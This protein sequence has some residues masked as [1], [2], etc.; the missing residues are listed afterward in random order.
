MYVLITVHDKLCV[1]YNIGRQRGRGRESDRES[2]GRGWPTGE[3]LM[4]FS[5][6]ICLLSHHIFTVVP[7]I[8]VGGVNS[9]MTR[10][11]MPV[12]QKCENIITK[13]VPLFNTANS[14]MILRD[15]AVSIIANWGTFVKNDT[16]QS[17]L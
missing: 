10:H 8:Q 3:S 15:L 16:S 13:R 12:K 9:H 5:Q 14:H 2:E 4:E 7:R 17:L 1:R 6:P 11:A